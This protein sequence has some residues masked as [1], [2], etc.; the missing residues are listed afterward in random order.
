[1]SLYRAPL[2]DLRPDIT[3]CLNVA[4]WNLRSCFC[5]PGSAICI[6]ITQLSESHSTRNHT[7]LSHL[8]LPQSGGPGSRIYILQEQG[9]PV[10][11]PGIGFPLRCLLRLA[12]VRWRY[13]NPPPTWRARSP[14][15][16]PS[17]T[18]WSSPKSK[19]CYDQQPVY[20]CVLV[21]SERISIQHL[22]VCI[23]AKFFMLPLGGLHVK[24]AVQRGVWV[25]T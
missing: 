9:G 23:K 1:M 17:G 13:S 25:R 4:V 10:I 21:P 22:E 7:L 12:G 16:Y 18:R 20:Q 19:S 8:R 24:H 6:V 14:Y 5:G 2:Y 11:P 15:M 3:S